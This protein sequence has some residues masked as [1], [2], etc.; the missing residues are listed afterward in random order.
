MKHYAIADNITWTEPT[1]LRNWRIFFPVTIRNEVEVKKSPTDKGYVDILLLQ[2]P[3]FHVNYQVVVEL[4]Y[5]KKTDEKQAAEIE[6]GAIK[7]LKEYLQ[8]DDYL[9]NLEG[10]RA[11]VVVFVG[12]KGKI[13]QVKP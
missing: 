11:Y 7:Q 12:N 4:K 5:V 13:V 6:K 2:R 10:L 8:Y 1:I 9:K 3:P